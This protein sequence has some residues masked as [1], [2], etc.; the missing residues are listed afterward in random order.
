V[1]PGERVV[2][3]GQMRLQDGVPVTVLPDKPPPTASPSPA[4]SKG[5]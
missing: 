3:D 4:E 2:T 1:K 5:S